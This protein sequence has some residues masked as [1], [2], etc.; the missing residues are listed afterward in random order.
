MASA[1]KIALLV[2]ASLAL[3]LW[4]R[5]TVGRLGE[6]PPPEVRGTRASAASLPAATPTPTSTI[7]VQD[8]EAV[9]ERILELTNAERS[10]IGRPPLAREDDLRRIARGH[11]LD[12]LRRHFFDHVN[13]EGEGP[14]ERVARQHRRLVGAV[15]ENIWKDTGL[16]SD[17]EEALAQLIVKGWMGSEGHRR[18]I[19][20]EDYTHLGVGVSQA[21]DETLAT[22]VF[23]DV[24]GYLDRDLPSKASRGTTLELAFEPAAGRPEAER[25]DL[26]DA[27]E[28][29]AVL[30]P[31]AL[32]DCRLD[33]EPG[34]Y[35][36]RLYFPQDD[37]HSRI[38][39]GPLLDVLP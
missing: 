8:L 12:M 20:H 25:F 15:G 5:P 7:D 39:E 3:F 22:Q 29:K 34:S 18:N 11:N 35:Q 26:F 27:A 31:R 9:E 33:L 28:G 21:D 23:A 16:R 10:K 13:P 17:D 1:P 36:L 14:G 30:G 2:A 6:A 19:I 38:V 4:L 37:G 32:D 24:W